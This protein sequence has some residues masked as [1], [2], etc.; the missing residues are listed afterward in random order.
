M[1][2]VGEMV[3]AGLVQPF[4]RDTSMESSVGGFVDKAANI[5][6]NSIATI[7]DSLGTISEFQPTIT[8]VLDLT[9]VKSGAQK[10][11]D[12]ISTSPIPVTASY[13]QAK[14]IVTSPSNVI[15]PPV[16]P[17]QPTD[18][19]KVKFE[20]NIYAPTQLSTSDIYRQTRNQ[21]TMAKE[22]LSIP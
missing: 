7:T 9:E 16:D 5:F 13:N 11:S 12:Y 14:A 18:V 2:W 22:V 1:I 8:P 19:S 20:Q 4:E 3:I 21:I 15:T 10:I 6:E 17:T